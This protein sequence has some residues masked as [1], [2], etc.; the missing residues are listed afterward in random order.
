MNKEAKM[1]Q[2]HLRHEEKEISD[3]EELKAILQWGKYISLA[4]TM[5][6]V[7]Y[8]VT[9]SYGFDAKQ[10]VLYFHTAYVGRKIE[11]LKCNP[12][13][14]GTIIQDFGYIEGDCDHRYRSLIL[15]GK[16]RFVD[17]LQ[18]KI[19]GLETMFLH[20]ESAP[21]AVKAKFIKDEKAY[22][23]V[24]ILKL[25]IEKIVGKMNP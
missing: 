21:D 11:I 19:H 4:L 18:E 24:C 14:C 1:E 2:Y 5:D 13:V 7:P 12:Q 9:L 25:E 23:N 6:D 3:S 22:E 20:L 15:N 16:I 17:N 8:I 10:N